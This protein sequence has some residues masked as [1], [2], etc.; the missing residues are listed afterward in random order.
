LAVWACGEDDPT[1]PADVVL[2]SIPPVDPQTLPDAKE[3]YLIGF[4][5]EDREKAQLVTDAGLLGRTADQMP[6][7]IFELVSRGKYGGSLIHSPNIYDFPVTLHIARILG[8]DALWVHNREPV[9]FRD[10]WNDERLDMLRLPGIIACAVN[11]ESL[12]TLCDLAADW[13]PDRYAAG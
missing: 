2:K 9:H 8:G 3:F 11:K 4:Q 10:L 12:N 6:G 5:G 1:R 7:S 13:N